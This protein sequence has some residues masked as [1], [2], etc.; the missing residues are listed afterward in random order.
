M[1][2]TKTLGQALLDHVKIGWK[3]DKKQKGRYI[4]KALTL[5]C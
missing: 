3:L 1:V 2:V 4:Y 5:A